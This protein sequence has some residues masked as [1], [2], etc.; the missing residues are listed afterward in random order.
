MLPRFFTLHF[1]T[2]YLHFN[3]SIFHNEAQLQQLASNL[4]FR[5]CVKMSG[6][7]ASIC[8]KCACVF[9]SHFCKSSFARDPKTEQP[10]FY[11]ER[12]G[13]TCALGNNGVDVGWCHARVIRV[14]ASPSEGLPAQFL[15]EP[16]CSSHAL[17]Q[18]L[19]NDCRGR[20][21]V[22]GIVR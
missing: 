1:I 11:C 14:M 19:L 15:G 7:L 17:Q 3:L 20:P 8:E 6:H 13:Q 12:R 4:H 21:S 2:G 9:P 5:S 10:Q 22:K 18:A 16:G